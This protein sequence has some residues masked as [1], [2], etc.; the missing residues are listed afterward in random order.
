M[1]WKIQWHWEIYCGCLAK[2][3]WRTWFTPIIDSNWVEFRLTAVSNSSISVLTY[4]LEQVLQYNYWRLQFLEYLTYLHLTWQA[5]PSNL[6]EG[7]LASWVNSL[8]VWPIA[9]LGLYSKLPP[10]WVWLSWVWCLSCDVL[11][12]MAQAVHFIKNLMPFFMLAKIHI[13]MCLE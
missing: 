10:Q 2:G 1:C 11:L 3:L 13:K 8:E 6:T 12:C 7:Q 9:L 4:G 5:S